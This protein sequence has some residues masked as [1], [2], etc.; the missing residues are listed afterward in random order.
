MYGFEP[1]TRTVEEERQFLLGLP[2]KADVRVKLRE[3]LTR[4]WPFFQFL[5]F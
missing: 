1:I 2:I 3:R 4:R 5:L